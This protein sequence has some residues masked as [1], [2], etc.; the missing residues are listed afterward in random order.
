MDQQREQQGERTRQQQQQQQQQQPQQPQSTQ[1]HHHH[2]HVHPH[3]QHH[4]QHQRHVHQHRVQGR[5]MFAALPNDTFQPVVVQGNVIPASITDKRSGQTYPLISKEEKDKREAKIQEERHLQELVLEEPLQ[6]KDITKTSADVVWTGFKGANEHTEVH[7][8]V[9]QGTAKLKEVGKTKSNHY[10]LEK[11]KAG[12][13]YQV[14]LVPYHKGKRGNPTPTTSFTASTSAPSAM[15]P[16]MLG[17]RQPRA[18]G[19]KWGKPADSGGLPVDAYTVFWDKGDADM[20]ED[21]FVQ[22]YTGQGHSCKVKDLERAHVY[23]F[24]VE[25]S[26]ADGTSPRSPVAAI[27]TSVDKPSAPGDITLVRAGVD[28]LTIRWG[29][30]DGNG[31]PIEHYTLQMDDPSTGYGFLPKYTS[32]DL[33]HTIKG[34]DK[35]AAYSFRVFATNKGDKAGPFSAIATF[36]TKPRAPPPPSAPTRVGKVQATAFKVSWKPPP[37]P[38]DPVVRFTLEMDQGQR[39]PKPTKSGQVKVTPRGLKVV[40]TGEEPSFTATNLQPGHVYSLRCCC[41]GE[42]GQG[43]FSKLATVTTLPELPQ[44]PSLYEP[45]ESTSTCLHIGWRPPPQGKDG[46][47]QPAEYEVVQVGP[48]MGTAVDA[49]TVMVMDTTMGDPPDDLFADETSGGGGGGAADK[50]NQKRGNARTKSN[51]S[52]DGDHGGGGGKKKNQGGSGGGDKGDG[53]TGDVPDSSNDKAAPGGDG[54]SG[55]GGGVQWQPLC[56]ETTRRSAFAVVQPG[57]IH[58]FRARCRN[59][60]GWSAWS[61]PLVLEARA[62]PPEP[63]SNLT[64]E[65]SKATTA[66]LTFSAG[67][68]NGSPVTKFRVRYAVAGNDDNNDGDGGGGGDDDEQQLKW[69]T[70]STTR[71]RVELKGLTPNTPYV[72]TVEATNAIGW[73][74]P[75]VALRWRTETTTP[76]PPP[77]PLVEAVTTHSI[78]LRVLPLSRPDMPLLDYRVEGN[79][80]E[81]VL[82]SSD[83]A[84]SAHGDAATPVSPGGAVVVFDGLRPDKRYRFRVRARNHVGFGSFSSYVEGRTRNTPPPPPALIAEEVQPT[85]IKLAWTHADNNVVRTRLYMKPGHD[86]DFKEVKNVRGRSH[87]F[88]R[89]QTGVEFHFKAQAM[90]EEG[91]GE[92]SDVLRVRTDTSAGRRPAPIRISRLSDDTMV[93]RVEEQRGETTEVLIKT[94]AATAGAAAAAPTQVKKKKIKKKPGHDDGGGDGDG[95]GGPRVRCLFRGA[96]E[97]RDEDEEDVLDDDTMGLRAIPLSTRPTLVCSSREAGRAIMHVPAGT[98]QGPHGSVA[99]DV[100]VRFAGSSKRE[101]WQVERVVFGQERQQRMEDE[102]A[103]AAAAKKHEEEEQQ[104]VERMRRQEK[105]ERERKKAVAPTYKPE[106]M[107]VFKAKAKKKRPFLDERGVMVASVLIALAAIIIIILL[108]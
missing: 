61:E 27:A 75:S 58:A 46:G 59:R 30:A 81:K 90:N 1:G 67:F 19:L 25:C 101:L 38:E 54:R 42:G 31:A 77:L 24:V 65:S 48:F 44:P 104:R 93:V 8:E 51:S 7:V 15:P 71:E 73:S 29:A 53:H 63:P 14:R 62:M 11:L 26:N 13:Q 34:L 91:W 72:A 20:S 57:E 9:A 78:A 23:R 64:A 32:T 97:P 28:F 84:T 69:L 3:H 85:S 103:A 55:G 102:L 108:K 105:E 60:R 88:N 76:P 50:K 68:E 47:E 35:D 87:K 45:I 36:K 92:C 4:H 100:V 74:R 70:A 2:H 95:A 43:V 18:L 56:R 21:D 82:A 94:P 86:K 98:K 39:P 40:Y 33:Q 5:L 106:L 52:H 80:E 89:L 99:V 6:V 22:V 10:K 37:D 96:D 41:V 17:N 12:K 49:V 83:V 79:G 16:V 66:T 107:G